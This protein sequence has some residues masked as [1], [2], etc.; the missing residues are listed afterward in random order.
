MNAF[1]K[2]VRSP[3]KL[4]MFLLLRLPAAYFSGVRIKSISE[5]KCVVSGFPKT[6]SA[7]LISPA[8]PWPPK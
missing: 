3:L 6:R 8:W 5:E 1:I 7:P 4:R 2:M